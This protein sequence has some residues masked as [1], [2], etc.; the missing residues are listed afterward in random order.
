MYF[1]Q[2]SFIY[3]EIF[4]LVTNYNDF[5]KI[6]FNNIFSTIMKICAISTKKM[7]FLVN[8]YN[9]MTFNG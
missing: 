2:N 4:F 7:K 9:N 1:P 3:E 5:V 6:N 8:K